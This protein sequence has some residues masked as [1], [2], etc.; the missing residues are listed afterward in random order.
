M[1]DKKQI[2][3]YGAIRLKEYGVTTSVTN[4]FI[5]AVRALPISYNQAAY[6]QFIE[7]FGTVRLFRLV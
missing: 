1:V 6:F 5:G 3:N 4:E 7:S 2:C